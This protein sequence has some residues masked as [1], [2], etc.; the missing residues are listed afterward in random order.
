MNKEKLKEAE[1]AFFTLYPQGFDSE[2]L[3]ELGK[4]HRMDKIVAFAHDS[5]S[6]NALQ[7]VQKAASDM[8]RL[9]S[10]S[11]MVS[12]F[13]KPR[14]RDAVNSMSP[15]EKEFL[16]DGLRNLLF[17]DEAKGFHQ[18]LDVL[19][20]YNLAKWTLITVFRCYYYPETDLL[21]KPTTVKN[22]IKHFELDGLVYNPRPSYDFFVRYRDEI[23]AMKNMVKGSVSNSNAGF[24]GFLMMSMDIVNQSKQ[25]DL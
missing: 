7:N 4:K 14:F 19:T 12:V 18:I 3:R 16:V 6:P 2:A 24:S 15:D 22:V 13:E 11:S 20:R 5:F 17:G 21:Y 9:V 1:Q 8:T 23:N 25:T 10:S